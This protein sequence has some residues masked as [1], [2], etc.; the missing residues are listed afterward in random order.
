MGGGGNG[1]KV[2]Y[3]GY[4]HGYQVE[5]EMEKELSTDREK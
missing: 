3:I 5:I 2:T 4:R 1:M